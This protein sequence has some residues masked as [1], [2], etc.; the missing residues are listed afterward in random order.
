MPTTLEE[1]LTAAQQSHAH[2]M[3]QIAKWGATAQRAAGTI[4]ILDLLI[5]EEREK[6]VEP[7]DVDP[8]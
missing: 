1:K 7:M 8:M 3:E 5:K 6:L 2:A 4:D